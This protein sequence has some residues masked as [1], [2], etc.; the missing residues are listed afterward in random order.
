MARVDRANIDAAHTANAFFF[1]HNARVVHINGRR[2]ALPG[3]F[4]ALDAVVVYGL[5]QGI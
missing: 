4:A 3:A 5:R 1:G 2:W